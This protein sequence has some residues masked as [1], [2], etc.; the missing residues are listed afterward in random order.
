MPRNGPVHLGVDV[1][2]SGVRAVAV[3]GTGEVAALSSAPLPPPLAVDGGLRQDPELWWAAVTEAV[4]AVA[5][6]VGAG[7]VRS[8]AVDGTSGTLLV[9][10]A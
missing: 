4:R 7:R 1:G 3:D 5:G 6:S 10:D 8:L 9:T 2:T